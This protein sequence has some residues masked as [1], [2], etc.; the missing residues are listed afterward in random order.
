MQN[1]LNS[2]RVNIVSTVVLFVFFGLMQ[3]LLAHSQLAKQV[4]PL[5]ALETLND[6]MVTCGSQPTIDSHGFNT[7]REY[8]DVST[9][10]S[11]SRE[12]EDHHGT[13]AYG[14]PSDM[15]VTILARSNN[16]FH[17]MYNSKNTGV[18]LNSKVSHE[19]G[20]IYQSDTHGEISD[21]IVIYGSRDSHK[22]EIYNSPE[23]IR[24]LHTSVI[25]IDSL[26]NSPTSREGITYS[27]SGQIFDAQSGSPLYAATVQ[28]EHTYTGTITN[29]NG[30]FMIRTRSMP[31]TIVVRFIGYESQRIAI[32][33][34]SAEPIVVQLVPTPVSMGE[35]VVTG[36]DPA[37]RI[38]REVIAR[39]PIWRDMLDSYVA[40]AY[41]RQ[42]L[43]NDTGIVSITESVSRVYWDKRRG[44]REVLVHRQQT[45]NM[46]ISQN[47]AGATLLPNF[48][49]DNI[50]ISGFDLVGVTHPDALRYYHFKLEGF[51]ELDGHTVYDISVTPRRRLQPT[52]EGRIAVLSEVYALLEVDLRPGDSVM[53]PPPIQEFGLWYRQQFSN[54]GQ[55]F[56]LPVDI[57]IEG[58]IKFGFPGLQF[59]AV[60]FHQMSRLS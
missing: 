10:V 42:R 43:E 30:E 37:I 21:H 14:N 31:V 53:F 44:S 26:T 39:K 41:T 13:N 36:E 55:D 48:Y 17:C 32:D 12:I 23:K 35:I 8:E 40:E 54:F 20:G 59:P 19:S 24:E 45:S 11:K 46:D 7:Y 3:P 28:V 52:F 47:F 57:R 58:T 33:A 6:P 18:S 16:D 4:T 2:S 50:S 29:T 22:G 25:S 15:S 5:E 51:R 9:V 1:F 56:W 60:N 34:P 49:D 38:M 27:I